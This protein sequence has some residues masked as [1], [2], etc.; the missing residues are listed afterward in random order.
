[1]GQGGVRV[2]DSIRCALR[3]LMRKRSRTA[4][5]LC[6]IAIGVASVV[7]IVTISDIGKRA[8]DRELSDLGLGSLTISADQETVMAGLSHDDLVMIEETDEV[9]SAVPIMLEYS[10][11][12]MRALSADAAIWGIDSGSDQVIHLSPRYGRLFTRTDIES[13]ANVCLIDENVANAFYGRS[14]IVGKQVELLI[15]GTYEWFEVV[16]IVASGGNA[17]QDLI[18]ELF[19][20]FVYVPYTT[21]QRVSGRYSIDQ[22]AVQLADG[23]DVEQVGSDII[24]KLEIKKG[25]E[26]AFRAENVAKQKDRFNAMLDIVT[27]VLSAI[28][29]VSLIVAGLGIMT[30]MLVSVNERT[31]E[32]GIKKAIGATN[33][34]IMREFLV[35]AFL[36]SLIGSLTGVLIGIAVAWL[37]CIATG[38]TLSTNIAMIGICIITSTGIGLVFGAYP[39]T[40]AAKLRPVEALR[41]E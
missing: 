9:E 15:G 25:T 30:V 3:G 24:Q 18:A 36:L 26:G 38:I 11:M 28:A 4:L 34:T 7:L 31:S 16:G 14:N 39:S 2:I 40:V 37:G 1:M 23:V 8:I 19:P 41:H 27:L 29:G 20:M 21:M 13:S 32:I 22:I 12:G 5:T 33:R 17:M 10:K 6:S 35:E